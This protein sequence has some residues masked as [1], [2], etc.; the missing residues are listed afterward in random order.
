MRAG[1]WMT[2]PC[3]RRRFCVAIAL[4]LSTS[5]ACSDF[6][7]D[8]HPF[9]LSVRTMDLGQDGGWNISTVPRGLARDQGDSPPPSGESLR[10]RSKFGYLAFSAPLSGF[11]VNDA[12]GEAMN[13]KGLSCGALALVPSK[14]HWGRFRGRKTWTGRI[15]SW[16]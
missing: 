6:Y 13:E 16:E 3:D 8:S 4:T 10:W 11:P 5:S 2:A 9:R 14:I 7:M 1:T 15:Q 12:V